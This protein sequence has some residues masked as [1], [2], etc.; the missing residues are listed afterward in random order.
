MRFDL[1]R[2]VR[3]LAA[4]KLSIKAQGPNPIIKPPGAAVSFISV[5]VLAHPAPTARQV[6]R[7]RLSALNFLRCSHRIGVEKS[8]IF[9]TFTGLT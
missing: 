4:D 5:D 9:G 1:V 7:Y 3:V 6:K 2:S 8:L